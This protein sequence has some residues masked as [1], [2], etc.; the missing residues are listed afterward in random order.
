LPEKAK[1]SLEETVKILLNRVA[2]LEAKVAALEANTRAKPPVGIS[3]TGVPIRDS[4]AKVVSQAPRQQALLVAPTIART[5]SAALT[6]T[7][8]A[9]PTTAP[10]AAPAVGSTTEPWTKVQKKAAK[11]QAKNVA[12]GTTATSTLP[13]ARFGQVI[14]TLEKGSQVPEIQPLALRNAINT[15]VQA[16]GVA[17]V[18]KSA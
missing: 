18:E 16:T 6:A 8:T 11:K 9:T 4:Y 13:K 7:L 2:D 1:V 15:A 12:S 14:I 3:T 17:K 5:T 10:A